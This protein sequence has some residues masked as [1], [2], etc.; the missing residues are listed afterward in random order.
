[1]ATT[2]INIHHKILQKIN[3]LAVRLETSR[4][5]IIIQLLMRI[6]R[7]HD[8]LRGN[9]QTVKYQSDD[10][11]ENWHCFH[12]RFKSDEYEFFI[13]LRK[14]CKCSVSLLVSLAVDLFMDELLYKK[15]MKKNVDN[16]ALFKHYVLRRVIADGII[17]WQ[18]YWG[19]PKKHLESLRL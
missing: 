5:D 2:S 19:F 16:Y 4:R 14:V 13:D 12:I 9:F 10:V 3:D 11:R 17:S 15:T 8:R 7:D 6:M 18:I 1:M